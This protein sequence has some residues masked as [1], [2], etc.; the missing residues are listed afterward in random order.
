[1][2]EI[3]WRGRVRSRP[4]LLAAAILLVAGAAAI[5]IHRASVGSRPSLAQAKQADLSPIR[6]ETL[7]ARFAVLSRRHTN[8]CGLQPK[9]LE[10]I[11]RAGRL[12]GSCCQRMDSQRYAEQIRGLRS[13]AR[14]PEI[15]S[16]PYDI[17]VPLAQELIGFARG[18]GLSRAQQ[19]TYQEAARLSHEHGPCCCHCW[20]WTA[21]GGQAKQL[22]ARRHYQAAQIAAIWDL[23]NGCGGRVSHV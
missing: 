6:S 21:F 13:Y 5:G 10:S 22:I 16:D 7:S 14:V 18:I 3:N 9:S 15:P 2:K 23:E 8:E 19:A 20:R 1:M 11:A 12:Q 4:L 17:S